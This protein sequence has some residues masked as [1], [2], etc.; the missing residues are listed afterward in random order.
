VVVC[1]DEPFS[2][3]VIGGP[4]FYHDTYPKYLLRALPIARASGPGLAVAAPRGK[5]PL[6]AVRARIAEP[7]QLDRKLGA[8]GIVSKRIDAPHHA[9][10][11]KACI[12]VHDPATIALQRERS[13]IGSK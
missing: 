2:T 8:R 3:L 1:C 12:K 7:H 4:L 10:K 6:H 5:R 9:G 11:G 13:E